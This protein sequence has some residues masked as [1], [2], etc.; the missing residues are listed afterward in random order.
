MSK[1]HEKRLLLVSGG[2]VVMLM[3][4]GDASLL[5]LLPLV[6][7]G[8]GVGAKLFQLL[9]VELKGPAARHSPQEI[10]VGQPHVVAFKEELHNKNEKDKKQKY[11]PRTFAT[12]IAI[13]G[14]TLFLYCASN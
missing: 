6:D 1:W 12:G 9:V 5:L 4:W 13:I 14:H 10:P 8:G 3:P 2:L 7:S 11:W